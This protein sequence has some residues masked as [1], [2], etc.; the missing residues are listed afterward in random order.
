MSEEPISNEITIPG[1]I[2]LAFY[3]KFG[4]VGEKLT[5]RQTKWLR[6]QLKERGLL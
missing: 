4:P 5:D 1:D 2:K 3:R 6:E